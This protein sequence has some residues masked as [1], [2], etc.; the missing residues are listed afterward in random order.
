ME[1]QSAAAET[2]VTE[3]GEVV[4]HDAVHGSDEGV[5]D[6]DETPDKGS[7]EGTTQR[8]KAKK[9]E[10]PKFIRNFRKY[11]RFSYQTLEQKDSTGSKP[12]VKYPVVGHFTNKKTQKPAF[13]VIAHCINECDAEMIQATLNMTLGIHRAVSKLENDDAGQAMKIEDAAQKLSRHFSGD[14]S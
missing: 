13:D 1:N 14:N 5:V 4:V 3:S 11:S 8:P 9:T 6:F 12:F 10:R 7:Q 2:A